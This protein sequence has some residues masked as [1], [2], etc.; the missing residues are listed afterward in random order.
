[1][2]PTSARRAGTGRA[3]IRVEGERRIRG[4]QR[5]V[6]MRDALEIDKT[7]LKASPWFRGTTSPSVNVRWRSS[8]QPFHAPSNP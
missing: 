2:V 6:V 5:G 3:Q 8:R 1:M 4:F 7:R